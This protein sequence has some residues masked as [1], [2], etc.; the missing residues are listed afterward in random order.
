MAELDRIKERIRDIA[1]RKESVTLSEIKWVVDRLGEHHYRVTDRK[2]THGILFGV[3]STRF[4]VNCHNKGSKQV[5]AYSVQDFAT[6]MM[7]LG[8]L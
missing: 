4:M 8:L 2:A 6:A 1:D 7:E 3:G 5:K